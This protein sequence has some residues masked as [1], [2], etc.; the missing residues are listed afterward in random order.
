MGPLNLSIGRLTFL[1]DTAT[2]GYLLTL[3]NIALSFLGLSFPPGGKT[4]AVLFGDP[5]PQGP[6][7]A[8][9]WY[10]AYKKDEEKKNGDGVKELPWPS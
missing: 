7:T 8:L 2:S 9:G 4:N 5:D 3:Q 10:A 1:Y 6:N